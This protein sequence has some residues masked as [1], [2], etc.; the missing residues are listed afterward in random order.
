[1][2]LEP[3]GLHTLLVCPGPIR[4]AETENRYAEQAAGLPASAAKPGGGVKLKGLDPARL[5]EQVIRSCETRQAELIAPGKA[6]WLFVLS[7][8]SPRLG[9]WLVR[10]MTGR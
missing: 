2:E 10:K 5:A 6:R 9:D 8:L 4:S 7:A 1:L 3:E